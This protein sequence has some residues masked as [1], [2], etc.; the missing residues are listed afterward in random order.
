MLFIFFFPCWMGESVFVCDAQVAGCKTKPPPDEFPWLALQWLSCLAPSLF[1]A[2]TRSDCHS[3]KFTETETRS[4]SAHKASVRTQQETKA[5]GCVGAFLGGNYLKPSHTRG[6]VVWLADK[7]VSFDLCVNWE[8]LIF[9]GSRGDYLVW[10]WYWLSSLLFVWPH[11]A[12]MVLTFSR[13]ET[14]M[15]YTLFISPLIDVCL[16]VAVLGWFQRTA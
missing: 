16:Y 2:M 14:M 7:P 3:L 13:S 6:P 8:S 1:Y 4:C 12:L 15:L 11:S 5:L 10:C 9:P